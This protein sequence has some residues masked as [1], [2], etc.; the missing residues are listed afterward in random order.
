MAC[1]ECKMEFNWESIELNEN[2]NYINKADK[3]LHT[4]KYLYFNT[5]AQYFGVAIAQYVTIYWYQC[6][7]QCYFYDGFDDHVINCRNSCLVTHE[8]LNGCSLFMS[9]T[10]AASF[11]SY[12][13]SV[14]NIYQMRNYDLRI[15]TGFFVSIWCQ[16][17]FMQK[18]EVKPICWS[19]FDPNKEEPFKINYKAIESDGVAAVLKSARATSML[20]NL[21]Q[22]CVTMQPTHFY[23]YKIYRFIY[24]KRN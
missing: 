23:I 11:T 20:Y 13:Q 2:D 17:I 4:A 1:E 7:N 22:F 21:H 5:K 12:F 16:F 19:C 15:D 9:E 24:T 6:C 18:W 8:L 3:I 14:N 10:K